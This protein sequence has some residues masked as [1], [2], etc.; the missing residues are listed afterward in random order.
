[1]EVANAMGT[2]YALFIYDQTRTKGARAMLEIKTVEQLE[3]YRD[4]VDTLNH[5]YEQLVR[6]LEHGVYVEVPDIGQPLSNIQAYVPRNLSDDDKEE[7]LQVMHLMNAKVTYLANSI[8]F[9]VY[10]LLPF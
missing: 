2:Y 9:S 7:V 8:G 5:L 4:N 6:L 10:D 3:N 1:M